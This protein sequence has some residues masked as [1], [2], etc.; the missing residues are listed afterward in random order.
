MSDDP[1]ERRRKQIQ[2]ILNS[3][4]DAPSEK[5]QDSR[6]LSERS[7]ERASYASGLLGDERGVALRPN[8]RIPEA[9]NDSNM[10]ETMID[11]IM[12]GDSSEQDGSF[13]SSDSNYTEDNNP[14]S[15]KVIP[16]NSKIDI[17]I[18][19][20]IP[21]LANITHTHIRRIFS[22]HP[23]WQ[24]VIKYDSFKDELVKHKD[25]PWGGGNTQW[26]DIDT[27][28]AKCWLSDKFGCSYSTSSLEEVLSVIGYDNQYNSLQEEIT[29]C[30]W[31]GVPRLD[32]WVCTFLGAEDTQYHREIGKRFLIS[33]I[34]RAMEPG[35]K[36]DH[37]MILEGKTSARKSSVIEIIAGTRNYCDSPIDL[38]NIF[39]P[40]QLVGVWIYE[41]P[42]MVLY[43]AFSSEKSKAFLS[44]KVDDYSPKNVRRKIHQPRHNVFTST[45]NDSVYLKD[46]TGDRRSWPCK[47]ADRID[48]DL[49][50][51]YRDQLIAEAY[52][53]YKLFKN[54]Y[55]E[56]QWWLDDGNELLARDEQEKRYMADSW[57]ETISLWFAK[58]EDK[59]L[60]QGFVTTTDILV[61][62][63]KIKTGRIDRND[64]MRVAQILTSRFNWTRGKRIRTAMGRFYP[65]YPPK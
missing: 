5:V 30:E 14:S 52:N 56:Y 44:R 12:D 27:T 60:K 26:L 3:V 13:Y 48:L 38:D 4:L 21:N 6:Q 7:P 11:E 42:E 22:E 19:N 45:T 18:G 47:V 37:V 10:G 32:N 62:A 29:T 36:V 55:L 40:A 2:A 16:I 57:E 53:C 49:I 17:S 63:L 61:H 46:P 15:S 41:L 20:W 54:G 9:R 1:K 28:R 43:K 33:A 35:C 8:T 65:Y 23:E 59:I 24:G 34:A 51:K 25:S 58:N 39:A 31:D 50:S 64:E